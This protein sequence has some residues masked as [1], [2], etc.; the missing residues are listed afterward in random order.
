MKPPKCRICRQPF[1]KRRPMQVIC[2]EMECIFSH[3][4]KC[5]EKAVKSEAKRISIDCR[6]RK[7]KLKSRSDWA[8]EAQQAFNA[9]IRCRDDSE[10]CISCGRHHKGQYHAGHYRSRGS[11][12]ELAFEPDNCH[13]QCSACNNHKSGNVV[14]YRIH[15]LAKI[16]AER[17]EWL[18]G[19]HESKKYSIEELKLIRDEYR[20]KL[21]NDRP[22]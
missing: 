19:P 7:E 12:P 9:W 14:E 11:N 15:L 3:I 6:R 22:V 10:P 18:E 17:L 5:R 16:G 2:E 21:A 4:A 8:R 1:T 20:K 13:K